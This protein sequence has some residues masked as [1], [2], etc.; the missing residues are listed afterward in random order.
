M[1]VYINQPAQPQEVGVPPE[2]PE[3]A[4]RRFCHTDTLDET[5]LPTFL[6]AFTG[7]VTTVLTLLR[8]APQLPLEQ[9]PATATADETPKRKTKARKTFFILSP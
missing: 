6:T 8:T 2:Q 5:L 7:D 4:A 9:S 3:R 1:T